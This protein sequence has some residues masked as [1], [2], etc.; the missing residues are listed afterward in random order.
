MKR[1]AFVVLLIS[2][3]CSIWAQA[4]ENLFEWQTNQ[5]VAKEKFLKF[6]IDQSRKNRP[7]FV[8][9]KLDVPTSGSDKY[10]VNIT[11]VNKEMSEYGDYDRFEI[12]HNDKKILEHIPHALLYDVRHITAENCDDYFITVPLSNDSFALFF[13]GWFY[14]DGTPPEMVVVVVT[15]DTAKVVYDDYAYAYKYTP[16]ENF[17]IEYVKDTEDYIVTESIQNLTK[18]KIWK[19]GNMLKYKSWK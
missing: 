16:G 19:E 13:G 5:A 14:P 7:T 10:Y 2:I 17:A 3:A 18:Y 8:Y 9:K 4:E 12:Y 11:G 15:G 1:F 6:H